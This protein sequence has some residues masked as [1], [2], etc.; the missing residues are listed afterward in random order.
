MKKLVYSI[1][2][3]SSITFAQ[4]E[5]NVGD[6]TKVTSFD[7][8]DVLLVQGNENKVILSGADAEEVELV[9]KNGELKIR[10]PLTKMLSGDNVSATVYYTKLEAIEANEGSRISSEDIFTTTAFDVIA[11]EGSQIKIKLEV[12]RLSLR[13]ANGSIVNVQGKATNQ[14]IIVNSGGSYEAKKLITN[15]TVIT[16]NAGGEADIYATELVDA[17]VR[18]GGDIT[19]YGNPKQLNQ[20]IIAGGNVR[21]AN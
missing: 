7:Q 17:K 10:M 5:K 9:N 8:I 21:K 6:F 4:V 2:F 1:L 16:T 19:V 20:K 18:A 15:Q 12:S 14:D 3:I 11:K 13:V